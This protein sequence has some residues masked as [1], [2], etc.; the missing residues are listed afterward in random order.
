[1]IEVFKTNVENEKKATE[2]INSICREF[3]DYKANFDLEDCDNILRVESNNGSLMVSEL[4]H[5][6]EGQG[7]VVE[8]LPD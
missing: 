2:V 8:V 4:L 1:M 3:Q 5:F 6:L 7:L